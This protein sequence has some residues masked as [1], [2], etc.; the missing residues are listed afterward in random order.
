M[1]K[2]ANHR[3]DI[4]F[5]LPTTPLWCKTMLCPKTLN[6]SGKNWGQEGR[7]E[8]GADVLSDPLHLADGSSPTP[9]LRIT[10][11]K[12]K[13]KKNYF[14]SRTALQPQSPENDCTGG[15]PEESL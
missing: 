15:S 1:F 12:K 10:S 7:G 4:F 11:F 9:S 2:E 13:K 6:G 14:I 5:P 8:G 3:N